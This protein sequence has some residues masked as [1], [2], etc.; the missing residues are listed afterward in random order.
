[1]KKDG[2]E[3]TIFL[4]IY[5]QFFSFT[6]GILVGTTAPQPLK[7]RKYKKMTDFSEKVSSQSAQQFFRGLYQK[8]PKIYHS[9]PA[10]ENNAQKYKRSVCL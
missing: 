6:K 1:M 8:Q 10:N 4:G 2:G 9:T 5:M 3:R 7:Y